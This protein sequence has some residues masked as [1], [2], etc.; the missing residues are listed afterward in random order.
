MV[1]DS[2]GKKLKIFNY[3][4]IF[5]FFLSIVLTSY[6][7]SLLFFHNFNNLKLSQIVLPLLIV[8]ISSILTLLLLKSL[9]LIGINLANVELSVPIVAIIVFNYGRIHLFFSNPDT[10]YPHIGRHRFLLI[11]FGVISI[12]LFL[13]ISKIKNAVFIK[14]VYT[15]LI[16]INLL[17]IFSILN[18]KEIEIINN[19]NNFD[20]I[21]INVNDNDPDIYFII[22]D[23]YPSNK[24]LNS[25]FKYNNLDFTNKLKSIGFNVFDNSMSNYSRTVV[26]LSSTLNMEYHNIDSLEQMG[27]KAIEYLNNKI[28]NNR[29]RDFLMARG[30]EYY[31]YDGGYLRY[32]NKKDNQ[33]YMSY[34]AEQDVLADKSSS[35]NNFFLLFINSS[36]LKPF[37]ENIK[38]ISSEIY[39]KKINYVFE[40]L[41]KIN[42]KKNKKFVISHIISPHPP[43]LFDS[44]GKKIFFEEKCNNEKVFFINQLKNLN[45]RLSKL[46]YTITKTKTGRDKIIILQGDHGSRMILPN[47]KFNFKENWTQEA[48]GNLNAILYQKMGSNIK[49]PYCSSVNTFRYIF[50]KQFNKNFS[51]LK[52]EKFYTNFEFPLKFN[53]I[54]Y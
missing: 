2:K 45:N 5:K 31:Y 8:W 44:T 29:V 4:H 50:N 7:V 35:D 1:I 6:P 41:P 37:S 36:I 30:Y 26:S 33:Y 14:F 24:V 28:D 19:H 9:N 39:R 49:V 46:L 32:N 3:K 10:L 16:L 51:L 13:I 43:Y 40:S 18:N 48:F 52:D 47:D 20:S 23:M 38:F 54:I 22:L 15:F 11:L 27:D 42:L 25:F 21:N 53:K 17:P 12:L 34:N